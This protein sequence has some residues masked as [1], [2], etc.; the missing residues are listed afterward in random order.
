MSYAK[1]RKHYRVAKKNIE[2]NSAKGLFI[3][4][5][6]KNKLCVLAIVAFVLIFLKGIV[7]G[8]CLSNK[9]G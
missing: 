9:E 6:Y 4:C 1:H 3:P 7:M 2:S 8:Y 5:E